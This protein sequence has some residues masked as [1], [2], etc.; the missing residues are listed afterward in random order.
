MKRTTLFYIFIYTLSVSTAY[1][2]QKKYL[3]P[4]DYGKWQSLASNDLSADGNWLAW[5]V[6]VQ[7]DNDTLFVLN[8]NTN[9][10]YKLEFSSN[11]SFSKDNQ[12][13]AYFI[14]M[15]FKEAEKLRDQSKPI[16]LKMGLLNLVSGKKRS[17]AKCKSI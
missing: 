2:Q 7:E 15:P 14:G 3:T 8:R 16:E 12:W 10:Q 1:S 4:D 11:A 9:Q 13:L 17:G 5:Q 6:T